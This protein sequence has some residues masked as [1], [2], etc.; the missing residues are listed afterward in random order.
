M[1]YYLTMQRQA[2][3]LL[4]GLAIV[5]V[6]A[7][8]PV[9][10]R[11]VSFPPKED[12]R[13]I[14]R[15]F[16]EHTVGQTLTHDY[17]LGEL[18]VALR[19]EQA[20]TSVIRLLDEEGRERGRVAAAVRPDV[21][22]WVRLP[23]SPAVSP[24]THTL[25]L[26]AALETVQE[27]AVLVR[28]Q[29]QSDLYA[30]GQMVVDGE[31]SYGD[32]GFRTYERAPLWR[33]VAVW[34]QIT[35]K[36]FARGLSRIAAG[37]S[38]GAV[39]WLTGE[40]LR[41]RRVAIAVLFLFLII[42]TVALRLPYL[43][44]IEGVFGGDAF[45]YLSKAQALLEGRDPFAQDFRKGPLYSFLLLPGFAFANPLYWS[46]LVGIAAATA[47]VV[48]LVLLGR[49]FSLSWGLAGLAGV[50]LA[51]NPDFIWESPSG[52]ANTLYAALVV[53][54]A[55][56]YVKAS[57]PRW[58]WTLVVLLGLM[59]LTRYEGGAVAVVLLPALW[60]R[61]NL[62]WRRMAGLTAA[63]AAIMLIPQ[64]SL[65]W[66]GQSG[67]RTTDDILADGGLS[68]ADSPRALMANAERLYVFAVSTW[69]DAKVGQYTMAALV[70]GLLVGAALVLVRGNVWWQAAGP[71]VSVL[72][73]AVLTVLVLTKSE[74]AYRS[75]AALPWL[76]VGFGIAPWVR[77]RRYDALIILL[78]LAVQT[79]I[80][81][82]ILPKPRYYLHLL[83]FISLAAVF[84]IRLLLQ[85]NSDCAPNEKHR[86]PTGQAAPAMPLLFGGILAAFFISNGSDML[87]LRAEKYNA[88]AENITPMLQAVRQLRAGHG[89]VAFLTDDEQTIKTFIPP[90]RRYV[91]P[92]KKDLSSADKELRWLLEHNIRYAVE[93]NDGKQWQSAR[94]YPEVLEHVHTFH[95][96]HGESKVLVYLVHQ[97]KLAESLAEL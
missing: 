81:T 72:A 51:V 58:Q 87:A 84:G 80:I 65:I 48:V 43:Q 40:L 4:A 32:I 91:V 64:V 46:R 2:I 41:R 37:V 69:A 35:D 1:V 96:I 14:R 74:L 76:L 62:P 44:I 83:P 24:G 54:S 47:A 88:R 18:E 29:I 25:Q 95:T 22:T 36:S 21:D 66:S 33:A 61:E 3:V 67:I 6:A 53:G 71:L 75:L 16:G 78:M 86:F 12:P 55:W 38:V 73:L 5:I 63:A 13:Y 77:A 45:N 23:I 27:E 26:A 31:P 70:I 57:A 28:F 39:L 11:H 49:I 85:W 9:T 68:V 34:G 50:L 82:I 20:Q 30:D 52:L 92:G 42:F 19:G 97:K 94:K 93:R 89:N 15:V 60:W 8:L 79:A 59:F 10:V 90:E 56:A 17:L 7:W